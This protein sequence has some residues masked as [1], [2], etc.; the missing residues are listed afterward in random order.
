MRGNITRRGKS[1]WRLKFDGEPDAS[2]LRQTRYV[3]VKGKRADAEAALARLLH[4]HNI[5]SAIDPSAV[6]VAE[7]M[8]SWLAGLQ[9]GASSVER[10]RN[11]IDT[12]I[13]PTL[14]KLSVQK[15]KPSAL[16]DWLNV[17]LIRG[18]RNG[19]PL[20]PRTAQQARRVLSSALK[21]AVEDGLIASNPAGAVKPPKAES[22][23]VAILGPEQI[24][25]VLD[26]LR[27]HALYPIAMLALATG[28][29]RGE[30]LALQ[31]KDVD[32]GGVAVLRIERSLGKNM[33]VSSLKTRAG[34]R[35]ISLP[36]SAVTMLQ[37]HR[38]RQ[39]E[40]RMMLGQGKAPADAP[41]FSDVEGRP[42]TPVY[43]SK[44]WTRALEAHGLP[45]VKLHSLRHAHASALIA[46]GLDIVSISKRLGHAS[47]TITLNV[48]AHAFADKPDTA[49]AAAIERVLA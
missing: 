22:R 7:L 35:S 18:G 24:T 1:S 43:V 48:Y 41:V 4:E 36:P 29:R 33:V 6:T 3:T 12:Q 38:K 28:A 16:R 39:L 46:A 20:S 8:A 42:L 26:S 44:D 31:W 19:R 21:A 27:G 5:G 32:L 34:R 10:Y 2:G 45:R 15:L 37:Q 23:E 30:L 17:I 47:P 14:G 49:A 9:V 13:T 40:Q 11:I 25:A